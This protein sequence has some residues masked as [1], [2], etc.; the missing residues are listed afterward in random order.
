MADMP[1]PP[2]LRTEHGP[3]R[4]P[5][6]PAPG[7]ALRDATSAWLKTDRRGHNLRIV[8][9][10]IKCPRTRVLRRRLAHS[11]RAADA[12]QTIEDDDLRP[13]P[14]RVPL[15]TRSATL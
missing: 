3:D 12:T 15:P 11:H 10:K 9:G 1:S 13:R 4:S 6:G 8:S 2:R 5:S 14:S 7:G